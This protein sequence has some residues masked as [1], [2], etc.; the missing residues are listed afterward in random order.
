MRSFFILILMF[1]CTAPAHAQG[2]ASPPGRE[3]CVREG[4]ARF[5]ALVEEAVRHLRDNR[6]PN[7]GRINTY[8]R[9]GNERA[10]ALCL[11]WQQSSPEDFGGRG[12]GYSFRKADAAA[13]TTTAITHCSRARY[14]R[15]GLC[16]CEVV[17]RNGVV[18]I[19]FPDGWP[20]QCS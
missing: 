15:E 7:A 20:R 2:P 1:L 4:K 5:T 11:N 19:R 16:R 17:H 3:L 10:F 8:L 14:A 18:S 12:H 13:A 6:G 9:E